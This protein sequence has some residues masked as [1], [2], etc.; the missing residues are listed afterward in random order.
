[1]LEKV[2][3]FLNLSKA[4]IPIANNVITF[5]KSKRSLPYYYIEY[6]KHITIFSNGNGII[7]YSFIIKFNDKTK[8]DKI[9]RSLDLR[10]AANNISIPKLSEALNC[11]IKDRFKKFG[12]WYESENDFIS[13]AVQF[14]WSDNDKEK[15]DNSLINEKQ[16]R[17]YFLIDPTKIENNQKYKFNYVF[18]IPNMYPILN[19]Y[20]DRTRLPYQNYNFSTS[21]FIKSRI[22]KI[23]Y[24]IS[25]DK[26][27]HLLLPIKCYDI[28]CDQN[29]KTQLNI[30]KENNCIYQRF[31][32]ECKKMKCNKNV[33]Y[34]WNIKNK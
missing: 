12:F 33:E 8:T 27:I 20:I 23:K 15:E 32:S 10:D 6:T 16:L 13:R 28:E 30:H 9:Y 34:L 25:F 17:W 2:T 3:S 22:D 7:H 21:C 14:N 18:S 1:M 4:I 5:V 29:I 24:I 11:K 26:D 19:G 31:V